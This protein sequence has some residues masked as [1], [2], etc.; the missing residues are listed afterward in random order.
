LKSIV[1]FNNKG[2]VGKT[3]LACNIASYLNTH[4]R[5]KTLLIDADPQCNATQSLF[6]DELCQEIYLSNQTT[7][8]TLFD[9]LGPLREGYPEISKDYS[10]ILG[11]S[12]KF[13]TD[14]IP[15]HPRMS[16]IEDRLSDS[17]NKAMQ[18]DI[19][20]IRV[21]NWCH[22]LLMLL[23]RQYDLIIFDVGPSLGALNRSVLLASDCIVTPL[24]S[25]IFSLLGISNIS[26]WIK[27]WQSKYDRGLD[28]CDDQKDDLSEKFNVVINSEK[29]YR[30]I[31]YS[32]QQYVV[33]T[34]KDGAR[35]I[36]AYDNIMKDIPNTIEEFLKFIIPNSLEISSLDLG[37]IP[38]L[39]SLIP[40]SQSTR[41]PIHDLEYK[42]GVM[43]QQFRNVKKYNDLISSICNKLITNIG[44]LQ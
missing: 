28:L 1:F 34:F 17:W 25:D 29:K 5:K 37:R 2:G 26:L 8:S 31:G 14:I 23:C 43:G 22:Q 18:G 33:R 41:T 9:Y 36:K 44:N 42:D 11:S 38:Y 4:L 12:N 3:T 16:I 7:Y 30:L 13:N 35:P 19:G 20:G 27:N 6:S 10:P 15:G 21:T 40:L 39:Y 24:G 32:I